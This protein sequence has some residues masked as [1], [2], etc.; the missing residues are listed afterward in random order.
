MPIFTARISFAKERAN[1]YK[2]AS[3]TADAAVALETSFHYEGYNF[4]S[5]PEAEFLDWT[6]GLLKNHSHAIEG[7]WFTGGLTDPAKT[8]LLAEYLGEDGRWHHYT[9][10]FV[11][12]RA[13]GKHLVVEVKK[14]TESPA[15][16]ADLAR[17][18]RGEAPQSAE[19]R[20][21]VALKRW[22]DLNPD[23]LAYHVMFADTALHDAGK[24][25]VRD[26]ILGDPA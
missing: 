16:T 12:R 13:D 26:F 5:A 2:T 20:K 24:K 8:E 23:R 19:G 6:L 17:H 14:D 3:D 10:D 4:D 18:A 21:A 9:P 22:E 1:L 11:I 25:I 15:I 7:L